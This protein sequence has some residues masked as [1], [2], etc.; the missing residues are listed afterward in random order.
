VGPKLLKPLANTFTHVKTRTRKIA[1]KRIGYTGDHHPSDMSSS[2]RPYSRGEPEKICA[3]TV[4]AWNQRPDNATTDLKA[5]LSLQMKALKG[6]QCS[7]FEGLG[8]SSHL[9]TLRNLGRWYLFFLTFILIQGQVRIHEDC[10]RR[11]LVKGVQPS[12]S[13][14]NAPPFFFQGS[15]NP[16][17][18]SAD[19]G[20]SVYTSFQPGRWTM[21]EY[22]GDPTHRCWMFGTYKMEGSAWYLVREDQADG[23]GVGWWHVRKEVEL[24]RNTALSWSHFVGLAFYIRWWILPR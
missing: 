4:R 18:E 9:L 14:F 22:R 23:P 6:P 15:V 24:Y 13:S 2:H 17:L 21:L 8:L 19:W 1:K 11:F 10:F 3:N 5:T 16:Q 12:K 20:Y 7:I